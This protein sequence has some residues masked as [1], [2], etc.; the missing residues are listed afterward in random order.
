MTDPGRAEESAG[1]ESAVEE[2][3]D[4]QDTTLAESEGEASE[5]TQQASAEEQYAESGSSEGEAGETT[6]QASSA[7]EQ[8][9]ESGNSE[10]E[11]TSAS[12]QNG[13]K[14]GLLIGLGSGVLVGVLVGLAF[15]G[16]VKPAFLVGPGKPDGKT[17]EVTAALASKNAGGMENASCRDPDGKLVQ[18]L[19]P[20]ALQLIQ[21]AKPTGPPH[22]SLDTEALTPVDLTLSAQGQTQTVPVDIVLGVTN[23]HWCMK[24]IAQRQQ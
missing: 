4:Q 11:D 2:S 18:Q 3:P 17:S 23:G 7:E 1:E 5:A 9:A 14:K 10:G 6:Q 8:H 15:A 19:P 22:L 21:S 16:F 12:Q 20:Q 13:S 24:G